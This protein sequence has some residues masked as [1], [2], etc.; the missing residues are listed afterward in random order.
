MITVS[1]A[2]RLV[3]EHTPP[4]RVEMLALAKAH[5]YTLAEDVVA[6]EPSPRFTNSAMDGVTVRCTENAATYKLIGESAAGNPFLQIFGEGDAVRISTGAVLPDGADTVIPIED[7][8]IQGK[9]ILV[10]KPVR[11]GQWVRVQGTEYLQG[12]HILRSGTVLRPAHIA[13]AAQCGYAELPV[14][15]AP[16]V[17]LIATGTEII[18][19]PEN[20][21]KTLLSGQIY[22]ANTPMLQAA[23]ENV[24]GVCAMTRHVSDSLQASIDVCSEAAATCDIICTTGGVSVG[25]HDHIKEAAQ[26]LGFET[27][28]WR[29]RQKPGKPLFFAKREN[30]LLFGLPGNSVSTLMCFIHYAQPVI[31]SMLGRT[32]A[33]RI[34]QARMS[35]NLVN[36]GGRAE[37]LRVRLEY[38]LQN[39]SLETSA[40]MLPLAIPLEKQESFMLTSL[41]E[42]DGFVFLDIDATLE[43]GAPIDVMLL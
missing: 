1:E 33:W 2:K 13:L 9:N 38:P 41:T 18:A 10:K 15:A 3:Q 32:H 40:T 24:G 28:F 7:I 25:E 17:G 42:A 22:D 21:H 30:T 20:H 36:A 12:A 37:F 34:L 5:K 39:S 8:E 4:A 43:E 14:F 6:K 19:L 27:I 16:R 31:A 26:I 11:K 35:K 29:V 23:I